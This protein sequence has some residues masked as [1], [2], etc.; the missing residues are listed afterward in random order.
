MRNK[1][2]L[3]IFLIIILGIIIALI[4][5]RNIKGNYL[6]T[7]SCLFLDLHI[8]K[9]SV[10]LF[11][12]RSRDEHFDFDNYFKREVHKFPLFEEGGRDYV[13]VKSAKSGEVHQILIEST[14][15]GV[16]ISYKELSLA[17]FDS[18][19]TSDINKINFIKDEK[20]MLLPYRFYKDGERCELTNHLI[21]Q[22]LDSV[23]SQ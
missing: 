14:D 9:D 11:T 19:Y 6:A 20:N 12:T 16:E 13:E 17:M 7:N 2:P 4:L 22:R 18:V 10:S 21:K 15:N 5:T 8:S 23:L 1:R 3:L